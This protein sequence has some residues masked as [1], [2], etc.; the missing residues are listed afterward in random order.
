MQ[1]SPSNSPTPDDRTRE[2]LR[3]LREHDRHLTAYVFSLVTDWAKA[4]DIV[5]ETTLR[6]WDQF[7]RFQPGTNFGAWACTIARY[8]VLAA[9]K[10]SQREHLVFSPELTDAIEEEVA[11]Q[12]NDHGWLTHLA[13]CMDTLDAASRELI[14]RCYAPGA[15][16]KNVAAAVGR[17]VGGTYNAL[18]R[19]RRQLHECVERRIRTE[20]DK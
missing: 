9:Q 4:E 15:V 18:G 7:D 1:D 17:S 11:R 8:L 19:I 6:L 14:S 20:G 12:S 5:Q 10:E 16:I 2:F 3:L 13:A